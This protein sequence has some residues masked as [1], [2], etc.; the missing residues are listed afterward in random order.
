MTD[1][2]QG[3]GLDDFL[4]E[5]TGSR[6]S[7]LKNWKDDKSIVVWLH[8]KTPIHARY[9]HQFPYI[10]SVEDKESGEIKKVLRFYRFGCWESERVIAKRRF[11]DKVTGERDLPPDICPYCLLE[12][13]LVQDEKIPDDTVVFELPDAKDWNGDPSP[14][15]YKMGN[16]TRRWDRTGTS[17]KESIEV[18][19]T[20]LFGIVNNAAPEDGVQIAEQAQQLGDAVRD[21]IKQEIDSNGVEAGN[22]LTSPYA[23]KWAY[24]KKASP[25]DKYKAFRFNKAEMTDEIK[26]AISGTDPPDLAPHCKRG[27]AKKLRA[28]TEDA[29]SDA[30]KDH[31][32]LDQFFGKVIAEQEKE[33]GEQ[34]AEERKPQ[35][36]AQTR[37]PSGEKEAGKPSP[38]WGRRRKKK[39]PEKPKVEMIPCDDCQTP[40]EATATKCSKCGAEYEVGADPEPEPKQESKQETSAFDDDI[41]F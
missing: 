41:P 37:S 25:K 2:R 21:C 35:P 32:D 22:P 4:N 5:S 14:V 34:P 1:S 38:K 23:I 26:E 36:K 17:W 29:L 13:W 33:E 8:T 31:I 18:R 10:E 9:V 12:E 40:M 28:Y 20:Y 27:D 6:G 39:E 24:N 11:R 7:W 19:K 3:M 30:V 15:S 16:L